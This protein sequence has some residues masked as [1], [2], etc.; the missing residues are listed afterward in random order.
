[1]EILPLDP[2]PLES[3]ENA[4]AYRRARGESFVDEAAARSV[5][6]RG[7]YDR[8]YAK[9]EEMVLSS[10]EEDFA[11]WALPVAS[12]F[13]ALMEAET[14]ET[15][16]KE[17][18]R[19]AP[20]V[21]GI[22]EPGLAEPHSGGHRWWLFGTCG[23]LTCGILAITLLSLARHDAPHGTAEAHTV[24]PHLYPISSETVK[25]PQSNQPALTTVIRER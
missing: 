2:L 5:V 19:P 3:S 7:A 6:E 18:R 24:V 17:I 12:P 11:G 22:R 1:M 9:P 10:C 8:V 25:R 21:A 15:A 16:S 13:R 20:P 23:A 14:A 4:K